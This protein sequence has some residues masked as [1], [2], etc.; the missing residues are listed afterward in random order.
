MA[1]CTACVAVVLA[2]AADVPAKAPTAIICPE[3]AG[4]RELLAAREVRRYVYLRTGALPLAAGDVEYHVEARFADGPN[5]TWPATAPRV[6]QTVVVLP[7][8][9]PA[10][11]WVPDRPEGASADQNRLN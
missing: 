1:F 11:A 6:S 9:P 5:L 2:F 4:S 7:V 3:Q 8:A 10:H